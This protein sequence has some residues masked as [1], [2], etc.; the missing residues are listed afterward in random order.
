MSGKGTNFDRMRATVNDIILEGYPMSAILS[1]LHDQVISRE[2]LSDVD[3]AL[4][5]EKIAQVSDV[6]LTSS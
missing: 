6:Y 4:I 1:Q 5:C 2:G 3:K